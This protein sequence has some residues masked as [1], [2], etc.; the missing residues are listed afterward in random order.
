M[1]RSPKK[2]ATK[3]TTKPVFLKEVEIKFRKKRV[4]GDSVVGHPVS[5]SRQVYE[6][7]KDLENEAKEKLICV[8]LD[9]NLKIVCFEVVAIGSP[10]G[11]FARPIEV[12][13]TA[14]PWN[15][16]GFIVVHNHPSGDP[17]PSQRDKDFTVRLRAA[18]ETL[19]CELF[20]H[21][22]V[23]EDGYFSFADA[24]LLA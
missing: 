11:V 22:I 13:R 8:S 16:R 4:K 23:G 12:I 20:D 19:G 17:A 7:F 3:K 6:L 21:V 1:P 5:G 14:I 10:A 18:V 24:G 9:S 2:A 15:P